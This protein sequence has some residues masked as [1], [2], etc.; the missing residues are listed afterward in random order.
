M[1]PL[2]AKAWTNLRHAYGAASDLPRLLREAESDT[3]PGHHRDS[4]WFRLW[5]ALCHQGDAYT[6]S[7]A[8]APHLVAMAPA[9][10]AQKMVDP[11]YLVAM[12]E[13]SRLEGRGPEVPETLS[14][15]YAAALGE[16][17]GSGRTGF[18]RGVG[19]RCSGC[20]GGES[21]RIAWRH[22]RGV[23]DPGSRRGPGAGW[24][25]DRILLESGWMP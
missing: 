15:E 21:G 11:L 2:N 23:G 4:A 7:Y 1:L 13:L 12:I 8:A 24:E 20:L 25:G 16:A 19:S 6:A 17:P 9:K 5:S 18:V 10:L 22:Q 3:R 14:A